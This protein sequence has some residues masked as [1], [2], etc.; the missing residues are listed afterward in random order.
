MKEIIFDQWLFGLWW[1]IELTKILCR[2]SENEFLNA[3][4]FLYACNELSMRIQKSKTTIHLFPYRKIADC[5]AVY[6]IDKILTRNIRKESLITFFVKTSKIC[7]YRPNERE[8]RFARNAWEV[9]GLGGGLESRFRG[10]KFV[11]LDRSW[12]KNSYRG[13]LHPED[14]SGVIYGT[15]KTRH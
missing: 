8:G 12:D 6:R 14:S 7:F 2:K 15:D 3:S 11:A 9:G 4:K 10:S 13:S 1:S 5:L